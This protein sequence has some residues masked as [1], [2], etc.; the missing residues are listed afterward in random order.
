[1]ES[2]SEKVESTD[3][4]TRDFAGDALDS[5]ARARHSQWKNFVLITGDQQLNSNFT[6]MQV[7]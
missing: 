1:M 7:A 2:R 6:N 5:S 3:D 4:R